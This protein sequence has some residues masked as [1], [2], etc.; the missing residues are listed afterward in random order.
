M[1]SSPDQRPIQSALPSSGTVL[2]WMVAGLLA[3]IAAFRWPGAGWEIALSVLEPVGALWL[4]ALQ[5]L[6]LPLMVSMLVV[7]IG[8]AGTGQASQL[9][10]WTLLACLTL[11]A[12]AAIATVLVSRGVLHSFP[13]SE[14]S[15][16][17]F[18]RAVDGSDPAVV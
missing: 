3:G 10:A 13:L 18:Q 5:M 16:A 17:A 6:V 7:A 9:G 4:A 14:A 1:T 8:R 12:V 2:A 15:R 11:L